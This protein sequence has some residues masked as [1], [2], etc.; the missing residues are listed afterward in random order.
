MA[1]P[2]QTAAAPIRAYVLGL[3]DEGMEMAAIRRAAGV[4]KGYLRSLLG[5][6]YNNGR[7]PQLTLGTDRAEALLAVRFEAPPP[8]PEQPACEASEKFEPVGHRV[9]RCERCGQFA[10][11]QN[12]GDKTYL[13]GHPWPDA[14]MAMPDA[15]AAAA[16]YAECGTT[17]GHNRHMRERT[18]VCLPCKAAKGGYEQGRG[19]ALAAIHR[20]V[21]G[22]VPWSLIDEVEAAAHAMVFR[23]PYPQLRELNVRVLRAVAAA[24]EARGDLDRLAAESRAA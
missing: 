22:A 9:G 5:G 17:R 12:R 21:Q 16:M 1:T 3:L 19:S 4:P 7:P 2:N 13:V 14:G 20:A 24:R 8:A 6:E 10:Q 23:R 11:V 18:M 15:P